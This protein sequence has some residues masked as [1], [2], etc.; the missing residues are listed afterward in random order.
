MLNWTLYRREMKKSILPLVIFAAILTMYVSVIVSMY[1][2]DTANALKQFELAMPEIMSAVGMSGDA[3]TLMGFMSSYLYGIILLV[4][5]MVYTIIRAHGLVAEYVDDHSMTALVAAPVKRSTIAF[6]QMKVLCT[7]IFVLMVYVTVIQLAVAGASVPDELEI[8]TLLLMNVGLLCLQ[9]FIGGI[10]FFASCAF[11]DARYSLA[12]GAGVPAVMY[13]FQMMA[14]MGGDAEVFRY[15]TF[16]TLYNAD[17]I[18]AGEPS[19]A[20]GC[21]ALFVGAMALYAAAIAVFSKRD[22]HI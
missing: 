20:F 18:L 13:I 15:A 9:L 3:T 21:A 16:F 14:N 5:P 2:S 22:L 11:S 8:G 1:D 7:G 10:C 6:T 19:A 17:D 12:V 4:F